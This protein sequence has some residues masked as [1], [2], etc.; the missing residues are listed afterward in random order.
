MTGWLY[1]ISY[2][3]TRP[4]VLLRSLFHVCPCEC[5]YAHAFVWEHVAPWRTSNPMSWILDISFPGL[6]QFPACSSSKERQQG[7]A[8]L[9]QLQALETSKQDTSKQGTRK[10]S[11]MN[12]LLLSH[13]CA[14]W[15]RMSLQRAITQRQWCYRASG[16]KQKSGWRIN[17]RNQ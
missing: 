15:S 8:G 2:I 1:T 9:Y 17:A 3:H 10:N 12:H 14:L 7:S 4:Y 11:G 5:E 16:K 6:V 13:F